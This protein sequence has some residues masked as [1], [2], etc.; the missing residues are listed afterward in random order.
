MG[1]A[2]RIAFFSVLGVIAQPGAVQSQQIDAAAASVRIMDLQWQQ[3]EVH[4]DARRM[5]DLT[6]EARQEEI[7]RLRQIKEALHA[8]IALLE[9]ELDLAVAA[10]PAGDAALE[11][12]ASLIETSK[13]KQALL[14]SRGSLEVWGLVSID[15]M[16]EGI[17]D[18]LQAVRAALGQP[19]SSPV[20]CPEL[21]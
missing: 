16:E 19:V 5:L 10:S 21:G 15:M 3:C 18:R 14:Y 13:L 20:V 4:G 6:G 17:Q 8:D 1:L 12:A 7:Q 9:T 2:S 11:A